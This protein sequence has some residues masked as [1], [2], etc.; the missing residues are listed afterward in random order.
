MKNFMT[1][2]LKTSVYK[3]RISPYCP[4]LRR[5][6]NDDVVKLSL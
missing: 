2:C 6:I 5:S 3:K 4:T 1:F